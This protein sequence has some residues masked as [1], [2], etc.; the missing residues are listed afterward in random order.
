MP[1]QPVASIQNQ[2]TKGLI[3]EFSGL[4]FPENAATDCDNTEFTIVGPVNRREGI[5]REV[6]GANFTLGGVGQAKTSYIWKNVGGD[7]NLQLEVIQSGNVLS[8]FSVSAATATTPLSKNKLASTID[9]STFTVSSFDATKEC[10]YADGNGYLFVFHPTNDPIYC[11]YNAGTLT[12]NAINVQMRDF[13]GLQDNLAVTVRPAALTNE[14]QYNLINQGW[15]SGAAWN[16]TSSDTRSGNFVAPVSFNVASGLT[17]TGGDT[18]NIY[19]TDPTASS[20]GVATNTIVASGTVS[21]Y[22]GTVLT[23][24][25]TFAYGGLFSTRSWTGWQI[26]QTNLGHITG[27]QAAIGNYPSNADVWWYFKD[28]SGIFSPTTKVANVTIGSQAPQGHFIFNA[29]KQQRSLISSISGLTDIT[30]PVRPRT[31]IWFQGRIWYTGVDAQQ[32]ATGDAPYYAWTENLYFS[33]IV[34]GTKDFGTCYQINDPTSETLFDLLPTDGGVISIQGCGAIYKLFTYQNGLLVFTANGIKFITGSQGI[35]FTA[36]DY[37]ITDISSVKCISGTSFVN[38][39]GIPF[40]WNEDGIYSVQPSKT[41][42][43]TVDPIT[44]S[45]ILTFY[46]DIPLSSKK[47]AH[48]AYHPVDYTVQWI[49][50]DT[51]ATSTADKYS[52]NKILNYNTFN[53]AFFPYTVTNSP[54]AINTIDYVSGP[55]GLGTP[56]AGFKYLCSNSTNSSFADEHDTTYTDWASFT[57][58]DYSS[59][60]VTGYQIRGQAQKMFFPGYVWLFSTSGDDFD[61]AYKFNSI[62]D[63]AASGNSGRWSSEQYVEIPPV[64]YGIYYR[65]LKL[66]GHGLALQFK[67]Q[68]VTG[69]NFDIVGWSSSDNVNTGI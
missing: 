22:I 39:N 44:V 10:T 24:T 28:L 23:I 40:F 61:T 56:T 3:T 1:Q 60:F 26:I 30:T 69:K 43:M 57:P 58:N 9:I 6:N 42:G 55:G 38:V 64:N 54:T 21:S 50:K 13:A 14:H 34:T 62:W 45:T 47:S 65:R 7:G 25:P 16:A 66:R 33:Q 15:T 29:F 37:T 67:V 36:N 41:G 59:Y 51:E 49:Y 63:Y 4:N 48:G 5:D 11:T 19:C 8:F 18:C 31:G 52:Y 12:G 32:P 20:L 17:I 46:S 2:F 53:Q 68:S 27:W 35:G